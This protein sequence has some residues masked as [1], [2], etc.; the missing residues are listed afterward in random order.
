M[1]FLAM[2]VALSESAAEEAP[3]IAEKVAEVNKTVNGFV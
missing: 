2:I 1:N 3:T